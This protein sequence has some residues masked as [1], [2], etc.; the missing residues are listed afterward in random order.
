MKRLQFECRV[1]RPGCNYS[2][3]TDFFDQEVHLC[4]CSQ[5]LSFYANHFFCNGKAP[6]VD[7]E[8]TVVGWGAHCDTPRLI[9]VLWS[10]GERR[11]YLMG[12]E[13]VVE[14]R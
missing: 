14:I 13:G 2:T 1:V 3:Y 4:T 6:Y 7:Q 9:L 10:E 11:T 12:I 8:L 5:P